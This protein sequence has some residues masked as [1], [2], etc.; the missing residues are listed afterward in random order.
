MPLEKKERGIKS[1]EMTKE[2]IPWYGMRVLLAD[3]IT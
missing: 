3:L 2:A 1:Q